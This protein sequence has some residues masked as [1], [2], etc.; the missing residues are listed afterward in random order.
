[1]GT[2]VGQVPKVPAVKMR[3]ASWVVIF[4]C[5][6]GFPVIGSR[7]WQ[8]MKISMVYLILDASL[9]ASSMF[10]I[11]ARYT[12]NFGQISVQHCV[13]AISLSCSETAVSVMHDIKEHSFQHNRAAQRQGLVQDRD[14]C[15]FTFILT[16]FT[17]YFAAL[18]LD[19]PNHL[20]QRLRRVL[21][22]VL[23]EACQ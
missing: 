20:I 17:R 21:H 13:L 2:P 5:V 12:Q 11:R 7:R 15:N 23:V 19:C 22:I 18:L 9:N 10:P 14:Y 6:G 3:Q 1:M 16:L 4:L 8:S